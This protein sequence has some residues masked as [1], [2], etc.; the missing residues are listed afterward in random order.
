MELRYKLDS[1][2]RLFYA[3]CGPKTLK[4]LLLLRHFRAERG[5]FEFVRF[6]LV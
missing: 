4:K 1:A 2:P 3:G 5:C 6:E